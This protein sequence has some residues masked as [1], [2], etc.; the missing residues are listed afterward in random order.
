MRG[1]RGSLQSRSQRASERRSQWPRRRT[2]LASRLSSSLSASSVT[3]WTAA[4]LSPTVLLRR[5]FLSPCL[6]SW[7]SRVR[8][9]L[10][11]LAWW[12]RI[13]PV[14]SLRRPMVRL[15]RRTLLPSV[16]LRLAPLRRLR[17][18]SVSLL[19]WVCLRRS[20]RVRRLLT[21]RWL[22]SRPKTWASL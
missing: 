12:T 2:S 20:L 6:T 7:A 18:C 22:K 11:R 13:L 8:P 5:K 17:L 21:R 3:L 10:A 19:S 15:P 14:L 16:S 9:L 4:L 1:A